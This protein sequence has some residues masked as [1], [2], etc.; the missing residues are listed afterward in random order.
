[1]NIVNST[2]TGIIILH[3]R[4]YGSDFIFNVTII[5]AIALS[6]ETSIAA[7]LLTLHIMVLG[8]Q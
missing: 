4:V 8:M 7:E 3:G 2:S 1:V 5:L 6:A